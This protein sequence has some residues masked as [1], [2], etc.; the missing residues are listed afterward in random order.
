MNVKDNEKI[1]QILGT[2]INDGSA[3]VRMS[4][5]NALLSLESGSLQPL[6]KE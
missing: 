3:E 6:T 5:K 1:I 2:Y 4:A